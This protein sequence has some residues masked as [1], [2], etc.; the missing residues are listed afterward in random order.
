MEKLRK[1]LSQSLKNEA[2][3]QTEEKLHEVTQTY[4]P[5]FFLRNG[6]FQKSSN[7]VESFPFFHFFH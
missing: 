4:K 1:S 2:E 3:E 6:L 5:Y 7:V